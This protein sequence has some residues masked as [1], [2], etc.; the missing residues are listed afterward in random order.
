M[1]TVKKGC[2]ARYFFRKKNS[3]LS[4]I[5]ENRTIKYTIVRRKIRVEVHIIAWIGNV[6]YRECK[7]TL[8]TLIYYTAI[9]INV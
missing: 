8:F 1:D 3:Q 6:M 4:T 2:N 5:I 9:P 7:L